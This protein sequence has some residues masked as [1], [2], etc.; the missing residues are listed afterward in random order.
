MTKTM[1]LEIK[2]L[3]PDL[4]SAYL[5]FF[6][7]RAF[8]DEKGN[9]PNGPCYCNAPTMETAEVRQMASEFG[10]DIKGTL[11]RNARTA[12]GRGEISRLSGF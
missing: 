5:D 10:N 8:A 12:A 4:T 2:P 3:T 11:R 6:D 7:N 1:N 9:N